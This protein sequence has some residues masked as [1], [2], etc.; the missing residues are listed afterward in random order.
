M[1]PAAGLDAHSRSKV[2]A[3]IVAALC[4]GNNRS[5]SSGDHSANR[6]QAPRDK[7]MGT[8][9]FGSAINVFLSQA[10]QI[11]RQNSSLDT[12]KYVIRDSQHGEIFDSSRCPSHRLECLF[13]SPFGSVCDTSFSDRITEASSESGSVPIAP[14]HAYAS[15]VAAAE[16]IATAHPFALVNELSRAIFLPNQWLAP[17]L[18]AM[19]ERLGWAGAAD[20]AMHVRRGD[21]WLQERGLPCPTCT[22]SKLART[23]EHIVQGSSSQLAEILVS[24][25]RNWTLTPQDATHA[26]PRYGHS[27][28]AHM[29]RSRGR[30]GPVNLRVLLMSDDPN[31]PAEI[32]SE[33]PA[34]WKVAALVGP[35]SHH[36]E[37]TR[38]FQ[39][40]RQEVLAGAGSPSPPPQEDGPSALGSGPFSETTSEMLLDERRGARLSIHS[41]PQME[42]G[43]FLISA[44]SLLAKASVLIANSG[45]NMGSLLMTLAEPTSP[46]LHDLDGHLGPDALERGLYFCD[47]EWGGRHGLCSAAQLR[48]RHSLNWRDWG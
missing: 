16:C 33:L 41:F 24:I 44:M 47:I 6:V 7:R 42:L 34:G 36:E 30:G 12:S 13:D 8:A 38:A 46:K 11:L 25:A 10:V 21:K 9:G 40:Q 20:I 39:G 2:R 14:A 4:R 28:P 27:E 5:G 29:R 26:D 15:A 32:A 43:P 35:P 22:R 18:K 17:Q 19:E 45:S 23:R 1:A 48:W 37:T 3:A 31:A